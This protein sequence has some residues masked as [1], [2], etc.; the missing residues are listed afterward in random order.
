VLDGRAAEPLL[1]QLLHIVS[2]EVV[3][4]QEVRPSGREDYQGGSRL[5]AS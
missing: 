3:A 4:D 1:L 5:Q 2:W